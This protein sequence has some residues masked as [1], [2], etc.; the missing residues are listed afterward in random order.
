MNRY[1][2]GHWPGVNFVSMKHLINHFALLC[3]AGVLALFGACTKDNVSIFDDSFKPIA[4]YSKSNE[5]LIPD[6]ATRQRIWDAFAPEREQMAQ[7]MEQ[8]NASLYKSFQADVQ[9]FDT[10]TSYESF[11]LAKAPF[12]SKYA[13]FIRAAMLELGITRKALSERAAAIFGRIPY[14]VGEFGEI[15]S[16]SRL[17]IGSGAG[18]PAARTDNSDLP[19]PI[20]RKVEQGIGFTTFHTGP[21]KVYSGRSGG[22]LLSGGTGIAETGQKFQKPGGYNH[23]RVE[24]KAERLNVRAFGCGLGAGGAEASLDVILKP[25]ASASGNRIIRN[26]AHAWALIPLVPVPVED[27]K[28]ERDPQMTIASMATNTNEEFEVLWKCYSS[29]G[30]AGIGGLASNAAFYNP[31][32]IQLTWFN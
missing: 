4:E 10:I 14:N 29:C 12:M 13:D 28:N 18:T 21:S 16:G 19:F 23:L 31:A 8:M 20:Q 6:S 26:V 17:L 25:A 27:D 30:V 11:Q 32:P 22:V 7:R 2:R 5:A 15:T 1:K 9:A 3:I 24:F